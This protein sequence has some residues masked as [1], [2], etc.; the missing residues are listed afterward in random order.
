M[1]DLRYLLKSLS[2]GLILSGVCV[3]ISHNIQLSFLV[4]F[5]GMLLVLIFRKEVEDA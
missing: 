1:K 5:V 4:G 2:F 3:M